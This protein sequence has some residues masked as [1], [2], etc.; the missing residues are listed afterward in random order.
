MKTQEC[1]Q[2]RLTEAV[3]VL[4]AV[5]FCL[6]LI[7]GLH[8]FKNSNL[9]GFAG[10]SVDENTLT[11][12]Q[13]KP[14]HSAQSRLDA[15]YNR[16]PISFEANQGQ[17]DSSVKFVS[18][19]PGYSLFLTS[20]QA[21][22]RLPRDLD[23]KLK[24]EYGDNLT[25]AARRFTLPSER[26]GNDARTRA[27][28]QADAILRI[29]FLNAN[30]AAA[31][32]GVDNLSARSNY[33]V[34]DDP[35]KWRANIQQY[36]R[37]EYRRLYPGIDLIFHG[38]GRQLEFDFAV[39]PGGDPSKIRV[40]LQG[41]DRITLASSGDLDIQI[42]DQALRLHKPL[43]Y[44]DVRG[45]KNTVAAKYRILGHGQI[46][47]DVAPYDHRDPLLIDPQLSYSALLGGRFESQANAIAVDAAGNAY[48]TGTTFAG[49]FPTVAPLQATKGLSSDVFITKISPSGT[50][51]YSTF[52]GGG[53]ADEG[54][55]IALD[56]SGNIYVTGTTQSTN[57]PVMNAFQPTSRGGFR[58]AFV[59]KLN[60][61]GSALVYSSYIGGSD[62]EIAT[63]I[64][65]DLAG[66]AYLTG[67]TQSADFPT[68]AGAFQ[69]AFGGGTC[70]T[71]R[72]CADAFVTKIASNGALIYSTFL[73]GSDNENLD[74][75]SNPVG[76]IAADTS[77]NAYVTGLTS[78]KNFPTR[79]PLQAAPNGF[80]DVFVAK[81][82]PTGSALLYSTYL[83][84]RDDDIGRAI[85]VDSA[86]N[87]F[88]TGS[89]VSPEFP[90]VNPAQAAYGGIGSSFSSNAPSSGDAFVVK[91][92]R[93][94]A[95][96][97]Y[98]T[99]LGGVSDEGGYGIAVDSSGAAY[100][101]G[102]TDSPNF[103]TV[104]PVQSAGG[105]GSFKSTNAALSWN[106][107]N[108][109]FTTSDVKVLQIDPTAPSIIYAGTGRGLFKTTD[110]GRNWKASGVGIGEFSIFA[111]RIDPTNPSTLYA[112]TFNEIYKSVNGG[113]AWSPT[114]IAAGANSD[115]SGIRTIAVDP[116]NPMTLYVGSYQTG[117]IKSTNGGGSWNKINNGLPATPVINALLVDPAAPSTVYAGLQLFGSKA[118]YK[119]IDGGTSWTLIGTG[120]PNQQILGLAF[121]PTNSSIVYAITAAGFSGGG[122]YKTSNGGASWSQIF[123]AQADVLSI[124][125]DPQSPSIIYIGSASFKGAGVGILKTDNGGRSW[126]LRGLSGTPIQAIA[127]DPKTP[128]TVYA[129]T[130]GG[131]DAFVTVLNPAG[132][133]LSASSY[134]GGTG[135][136][137]GRGVGVDSQG[138]TY[139]AGL[140]YSND[141]TA[142][143]AFRPSADKVP[144]A[145]AAKIAPTADSGQLLGPV[146]G[147]TWTRFVR[148][149]TNQNGV[150][151]PGDETVNFRYFR[152]GT[153]PKTSFGDDLADQT[154]SQQPT[155][156]IQSNR[157]GV[158]NL[159]LSNPDSQGRF[160]TATRT[161][162]SAARNRRTFTASVDAFDSQHRPTSFSL[163][164]DY[165]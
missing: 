94:G 61:T 91:I 89:T 129:G 152:G 139:L 137:E 119:S 22:L 54:R 158:T 56:P 31:V 19:G 88:L 51:V 77:G 59:A 49:D 73:G 127:V 135:L 69:T 60:A 45:V 47:I 134:F 107:A 108:A 95:A 120:L 11:A 80:A 2:V 123:V 163:R 40:A 122:V 156:V 133:A 154:Q 28:V 64:A 100:V 16:L 48:V 159:V 90:T 147:A 8:G 52:L 105:G 114:N 101:T 67:Y 85:T 75:L 126:G 7:S 103:P 142:L 102:F 27:S 70:F 63:A 144:D 109:G 38:D 23:Q 15:A 82:N 79:S 46:N 62:Q 34:G 71:N 13:L 115:I 112:G 6:L 130:A 5:L 164:Q 106:R 68:T 43:V 14:Q 44:Q 55:G 128:S 160:Q 1:A 9:P 125:V 92:D 72:P 58:E 153:S 138:N 143:S 140:S 37:V 116:K 162:R 24:Q 26:G 36:S 53:L 99:F 136:D 35:Q 150:P 12:P 104:D 132:K 131:S 81:L 113:T 3:P 20:S 111:L 30:H 146:P 118:A 10:T 87:A 141:F 86:G 110:S 124:A 50:L 65:V 18:R 39:A 66:N 57:F 41:A 151:D 83:G 157:W 29:K 165:V 25:A 149:D 17:T 93:T 78:S 42:A 74:F 145:F 161:T 84:G 21:V 96:I 76:G 117:V 33:F 32:A 121:D 98:S 97:V 4:A 155:L 148:V